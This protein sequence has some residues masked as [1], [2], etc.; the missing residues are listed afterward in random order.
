M[1][2]IDIKDPYGFIYITTNM[3]NG[4]RYIGQ[5]KFLKGK[6]KNYIGSGYYFLK[7][8]K[9]Y[10][11]ENFKRNIVDIAYSEDELNTKEYEWIKNYNAV[12]SDDYYNAIEGG[13][14]GNHLVKVHSTPVICLNNRM[15]FNSIKEASEWSGHTGSTIKNT[16]KLSFEKYKY[17]KLIFKPLTVKCS[18]C[19]EFFYSRYNMKICDKCR[20]YI[21]CI[22]CGKRMEK[23]EDINGRCESCVKERNEIIKKLKYKHRKKKIELSM[24]EF[25]KF[26]EKELIKE[27]KHKIIWLESAK[28]RT[29]KDLNVYQRY[30]YNLK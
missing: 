18:K 10:G 19:D 17:E 3:I 23:Y 28:S 20:G 9:K 2:K 14:T 22:D 25:N 15:I 13:S 1:Q 16:F 27:Q 24:N 8:V 4:K 7:A 30:T 29:R 5:K 26:I 21:H 11:K 12:E 6:W